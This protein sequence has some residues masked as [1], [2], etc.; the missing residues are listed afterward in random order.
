L[1]VTPGTTQP[2]DMAT[3]LSYST[4]APNTCT[5]KR[6]KRQRSEASLIVACKAAQVR[7]AT[8]VGDRR[9]RCAALSSGIGQLRAGQFQPHRLQIR[10]GS[11]IA[12]AAKAHLQCSRTDACDADQIGQPDRITRVLDNELF[13]AP[14]EEGSNRAVCCSRCCG[15]ST[16]GGGTPAP[17]QLDRLPADARDRTPSSRDRGTTCAHNGQAGLQLPLF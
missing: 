8:A 1:C 6:R 5:V 14:Y 3:K 9:Y 2:E 15:A 7:E 4:R 12:T 11:H 16:S 13:D 17:M 10:Y